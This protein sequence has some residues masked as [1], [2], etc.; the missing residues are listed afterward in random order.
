L[1][2]DV[3]N[4]K[5]PATVDN[6]RGMTAS[7]LIRRPACLAESTTEEIRKPL[8]EITER[9]TGTAVAARAWHS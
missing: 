4:E 1:N 5:I 3:T 8:L 7:A 9:E 2:L 6:A